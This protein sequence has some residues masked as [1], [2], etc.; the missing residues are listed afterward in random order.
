MGD[1]LR[2]LGQGQDAEQFY[3]KDLDIA[4]RLA[5]AEPN[6]AD[7]QTDLVVSLM[8]MVQIEPANATVHLERALSIL[9]TLRDTKSLLPKFEPWISSLEK[10]LAEG[11]Q[12]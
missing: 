6:R 3:R 7:Y 12:P 9:T 5:K 10:Q 8:R 2:D 1:L 4:E 11:P